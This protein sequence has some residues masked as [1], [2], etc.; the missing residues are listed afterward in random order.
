MAKAL[1][2]KVALVTGAGKR[3]GR[4]IAL[5]IGDEGG[6]VIVH[7]RDSFEEAEAVVAALKEKN[8]RSWALKADLEK[9]EEYSTLIKRA[10][11]SAGRLDILVNNASIFQKD[12]LKDV[13]LESLKRHIEVNAW[14]PFSLIR[15][16][17]R[18]SG[19]GKVV[20]LI[21]ARVH[22]YDWAHV[23]YILSKHVLNE[24]TKMSAI[25]F[26]PDIMIN[27][28]SPGLILP[29]PGAEHGYIDRL[30]GTVP[31]KRHGSPADIAD[32]VLYLL[33]SDFL[34]GTIIDVDGG[35]HLIEYQ[36]G[37]HTDK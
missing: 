17:A 35:R 12:T 28:V 27:G 9:P 23:A 22:G 20:N 11:D 31:L 32:A 16:F 4:A 2:G 36:G 5:A 7:Y 18:F 34:T 19:R 13:T 29:P 10:V 21:D 24:L 33:K 15:D 25:E 26:A 3:I 6:D 37:P 8:V 14:A 1:E 30:K